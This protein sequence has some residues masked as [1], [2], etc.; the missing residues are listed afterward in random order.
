MCFATNELCLQFLIYVLFLPFKSSFFRIQLPQFTCVF[1]RSILIY[2]SSVISFWHMN[3]AWKSSFM[4]CAYLDETDEYKFHM[5]LHTSWN[6]SSWH[7]NCACIS[8]FMNFAF[9]S[10]FLYIYPNLP[11]YVDEAHHVICFKINELIL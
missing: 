10:W 6:T 5:E 4:N 2:I 1:V 3:C 8:S 11:A 9:K 7:M